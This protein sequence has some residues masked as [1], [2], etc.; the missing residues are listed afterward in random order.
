[1]STQARGKIG[2]RNEEGRVVDLYIPR[3]C[4]ATN[5]IIGPKDHASVQINI[6]DVDENGVALNTQ[7]TFAIS[8]RVR[9]TGTSDACMNRLLSE[10]GILSF[11]K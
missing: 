9:A 10:K 6:V 4:S 7:T 5:K 3:K 11:S 2:I 8:G 1:M